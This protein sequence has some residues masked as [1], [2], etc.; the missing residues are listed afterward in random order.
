MNKTGARILLLEPTKE[1]LI[2]VESTDARRWQEGK[3]GVHEN[4]E[5]TVGRQIEVAE[6]HSQNNP[7]VFFKIRKTQNTNKT[8]VQNSHNQNAH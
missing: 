7:H 5:S 2:L 4:S 8:N 3:G 1:C 6:E